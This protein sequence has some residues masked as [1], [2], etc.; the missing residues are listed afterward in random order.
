MGRSRR[1]AI[2]QDGSWLYR[3]FYDSALPADAEISHD[4]DYVILSPGGGDDPDYPGISTPFYSDLRTSTQDLVLWANGVVSLGP[5]TQ[6][7]IDFMAA[8]SDSTDMNLFPGQYIAVGFIGGADEIFLGLKYDHTEIYFTNT[9]TGSNVAELYIYADHIEVR[10]A[11]T[12]GGLDLGTGTVISNTATGTI[13]YD[14]RDLIVVKGTP[15]ADTL[16]GTDAPQT[17][18]GGGGDDIVT[19]ALGPLK[20][21]GGDGNDT[22]SGSGRADV[23]MGGAGND[24]I[25]AGEYDLVD[26]GI[27]NDTITVVVG[28]A[29]SARTTISGGTGFDTLILDFSRQGPG[30]SF[31]LPAP[32]DRSIPSPAIRYTGIETFQLKGS[33]YNDTLR[34]NS[35]NDVLSGGFGADTLVGGAGDDTLDAGTGPR[36]SREPVVIAG[37]SDFGSAVLLDGKFTQGPNGTLPF[38]QIDQLTDGSDHFNTDDYFAFTAT[39]GAFL[40]V[41]LNQFYGGTDIASYS[42]TLYDSLGNVVAQDNS[43]FSLYPSLELTN[44]DAG[45]YFLEIASSNNFN[46]PSQFETTVT[47]SSGIVPVRHDVLKGGTGNDTYLVYADDDIITEKAGEGYDKVISEVSWQLGSNL[48]ELTLS[49]TSAINGTGNALGNVLTGNAAANVLKGLDGA[50]TLDGG[51]GADIM[52]GGKGDDTYIVDNSSDRIRELAG[53]GVDTV[54]SSASFTLSAEVEKLA[55]TGSAAIN[56]SGNALG[57]T[58]SGNGAA[59]I[60]SGGDGNDVLNGAGGNDTLRGGTGGDRLDGGE[61][62]DLLEGGAGADLFIFTTAGVAGSTKSTPERVLDFSHAERDQIDLRGIDANTTLAG[63][64]AFTFIGSAAFG[65]HAGELRAL[66]TTLNTY[67]YGDTNGD[68]VADF[69]IRLDGAPVLVQGDFLL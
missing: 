53:E 52:V 43:G 33:I 41:S 22:I 19:G 14:L 18:Y 55:L 66:V 54:R 34:G 31:N 7:Q 8:A 15:N 65:N 67:V 45:T 59:N 46:G 12:T 40:S 61:G 38:V 50:D 29:G 25:R 35:G 58:I 27:G 32:G 2:D 68:G 56:G 36:Q 49:G 57:N 42:L 47:L 21:Y 44:L 17:I 9:F 10:G 28:P 37:G 60:L 63:D 26:G 64:Q 16:A 30:F 39:D 11:L 62:I 6:D 3:T 1:A 23:I 24:T 4:A 51:G 69:A 5:V 13:T 20:V 48:E